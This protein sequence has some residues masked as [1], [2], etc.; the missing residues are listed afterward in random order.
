MKFKLY[1]TFYF[2]LWPPPHTHTY[3]QTQRETEKERW[4]WWWWWWT[5]FWK[6]L[7]K[8]HLCKTSC[9]VWWLWLRLLQS[10]LEL[11]CYSFWRK[12]WARELWKH[13]M[14]A[15]SFSMW[16]VLLEVVW[17]PDY[18]SLASETHHQPPPTAFTQACEM[19]AI[20]QNRLSKPILS[21]FSF[22]LFN[23][24]VSFLVK[25]FYYVF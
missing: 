15:H 12:H 22:V 17:S 16:S 13:D 19:A 25:S 10:S 21:H 4:W 20:G 23:L 18:L 8:R 14:L 5:T 9:E 3:I 11:A 2:A 1:L 7:L 24:F 6:P